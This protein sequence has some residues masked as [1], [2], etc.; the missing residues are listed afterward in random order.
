MSIV[1]SIPQVTDND[2]RLLVAEV[3]VKDG[4]RVEEGAVLAMLE[5]SKA[6]VELTA[7]AAGWVR[8]LGC[9]K[10]AEYPIGHGFCRIAASPDEKVPPARKT[11][12]AAPK[13]AK[14]LKAPASLAGDAAPQVTVTPQ[15]RRVAEALG[16]DPVLVGRKV[17][18][19]RDLVPF[20]ADDDSR[21]A[22]LDLIRKDAAFRDLSSPLKVMAYRNAGFDVAE[23]VVLDPGS[24]L[25][26]PAIRIA[27]G[28]HIGARTVIACDRELA[29]GEGT[30]IGA[31]GDIECVRLSVGSHVRIMEKVKMDVAGGGVPEAGVSIGDRCLVS[32]GSYINACRPVRMETRA[33]LSPR[34]MIFT[35]RFWHNVFEG[36]DAAFAPVT[37]E[38]NAWIGASAQV[39]PGVTVGA[40]TQV[41]SGSMVIHSLPAHSMAAGIPAKVLRQ[42]ICR[43]LSAEE[44]LARLDKEMGTF[45]S[46][47]ESRGCT[48]ERSAGALVRTPSGTLYRL[49]WPSYPATETE[50]AETI[51]IGF[52]LE[53][54]GTP[55]MDLERA[56]FLGPRNQMIDELREFFRRRGLDFQPFDWSFDR[57]RPL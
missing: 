5:T 12:S 10:G 42:D 37:L 33:A 32:A 56:V 17:V 22:F 29:I 53:D 4:D 55:A 8:D 27:E 57:S 41:M 54:R 43:D 30:G 50:G 48:V 34:A 9:E 49:A 28:V 25:L 14:P 18:R 51:A 44:K 31:D 46:I 19:T 20:M 26:A 21:R 15:A 1:V 35:H 2:D 6:A 3:L 7:P 24:L 23:N 47:L 38:E 11:R 45:L 16:L 13:P 36:H 39:G 52:S 40:G